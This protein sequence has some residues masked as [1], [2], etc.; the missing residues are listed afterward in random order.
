MR[1][2]QELIRNTAILSIGVLFTR[3]ISFL[4]LPFYTLYISPSEYGVTDL[5]LTY[6]AYLAPFIILQSDWAVFKFLIDAHGDEKKIKQISSTS[7]HMASVFT[8][9]SI[10]ALLVLNY[11]I[12]IPYLVYIILLLIASVLAVVMLQYARGLGKNAIY[13]V[14][15]IISGT[16]G[17]LSFFIFVAWL[18]L[19]VEGILLSSVIS[20]LSGAIYI[21]IVLKVYRYISFSNIDRELR[22]KMLGYSWPLAPEGISWWVMN[23]SDRTII[24]IVIGVA[25]NGVYAVA[26]KY[27]SIL[28][29]LF[30]IFNLSWSQSISAHINDKDSFVSDVV[31]VAARLFGSIGLMLIAILP[32]IFSLIINHAYNE[33]YMYVPILVLANVFYA[34]AGIYSG[35]YIAKNLTKQ[36]AITTIVASIINIIVNLSLI[37]Y[38]GV[39]AAAI[40]TLIAYIVLALYRHYDVQKYV[41]IT[42]DKRILTIMV[43]LYG[44]VGVLYYINNLSGNIVSVIITAIA[45]IALNKSIINV[46]K[47]KVM[48]KLK[49][50]SADQT[51]AEEINDSIF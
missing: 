29:I 23:A 46:M 38:I 10:S 8:A 11:F 16:I 25:A 44:F 39:Y 31:N 9:I 33:A 4:L 48:S 35:V 26:N 43:V 50:L 34:I 24:S 12:S 47:N 27:A 30:G 36:I 13:S 20:Q 51:V 7:A 1:K 14:S 49:P 6:V 40:S 45:V 18:S 15:S 19:G 28:T 17:I 21:I 37:F 32:L 41:S 42:Y 2:K 22:K 5:I 3:L